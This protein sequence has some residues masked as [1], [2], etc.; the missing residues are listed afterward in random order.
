MFLPV[1]PVFSAEN[2]HSD[3]QLAKTAMSPAEHSRKNRQRTGPRKKGAGMIL[4]VHLVSLRSTK[5]T[6]G[7]FS[8]TL[9]SPAEYSRKHRQRTGPL[10]KCAGKFLTG[11]VFAVLKAGGL[12]VFAVRQDSNVT[13]GTFAEASSADW[14]AKEGCG[15]VLT[16]ALGFVQLDSGHSWRVFKHLDVTFGTFAEASS[17]D[18]GMFHGEF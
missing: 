2:T 10:K 17:A 12:E 4:P 14:S 16:G 7:V 5:V 15:N 6:S 8:N 3:L 1:I 11:N 9:M 18:A 13:C